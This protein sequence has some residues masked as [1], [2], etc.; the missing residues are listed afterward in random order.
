[1]HEQHA[2]QAPKTTGR[3]I[4]W[5]RWY[6][7][8]TAVLSFGRSSELYQQAMDLAEPKPGQKVLDVGSGTGTLAIMLG[9][10]VAP[11]G[12]VVG[13]DA[14][15]EM[16]DVAQSKAKKQKSSARF[17]PAAIE[18][19]PF[20]KDSFD[21][22]TSSLMLHHLPEDVQVK[23]LAE[24]RRVLRPGG[25]FAVVDFSSDSGTFLGHLMAMFGHKHGHSTASSH[26]S[27]LRSAG[28]TQVE[29]VKTDRKGLM[30]IKAS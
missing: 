25:R 20:E 27:K 12:E 9:E 18:S 28:F 15:T 7:L 23:G 16:I 17:Q 1:M 3:T 6:D 26:A 29:E 19:L 8:L 21:L 30:S 22:V 2:T 24:V 11:G 5:A 14:S 4:R 13:I 10:A